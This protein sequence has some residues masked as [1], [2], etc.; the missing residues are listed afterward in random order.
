MADPDADRDGLREGLESSRG[1][2]R[3]LAVLNALLSV[4]FAVMIVRGAALVGALE[5]QT[6]TVAGVAV[7]LF[8]LTSV[9]TRR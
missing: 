2:P 6:T 3:V 9:M 1:D 8:V 7:A 5:Y 4:L